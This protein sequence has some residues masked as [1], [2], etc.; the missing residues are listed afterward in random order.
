MKKT[1]IIAPK[2]PLS[3]ADGSCMR[4]MN[5]VRY[6]KRFGQVDILCSKPDAFDPA[7]DNT[8]TERYFI[9]FSNNHKI[10]TSFIR[11]VVDK[12]VYLRS[13]YVNQ[14]TPEIEEYIRDIVIKGNYDH[15]LCRY[16]FQ[17]YPLLVLDKELK[18]RIILDVDDVVTDSVYDAGTRH[19]TGFKR[20]N[21]MIDKYTLKRYYARCM[22]FGSI[23][24]CSNDD[25]TTVNEA[26]TRSKSYIVPNVCPEI[27]LPHHYRLEGYDYI[28]TLLFVG[29]LK[30]EPNLQGIIW[31]IEKIF[32]ELYG[33][34]KD[35]RLIVAG[36]TPPEELISLVKKHPNIEL[37]ENPPDIMPFY[38]QCGLVIV[39]LCAGGGTRIKIL[40]AGGA[41]RPVIST[42]IG[43]YGLGLTEGMEVLMFNDASS[44][45]AKYSQL[46]SNRE[47]YSTMV[48]NL[49]MLIKRE[50][51]LSRFFQ[52]M[53][54]VLQ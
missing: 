53:D 6:F 36:R 5:F 17:A 28:N 25:I 10:K 22:T 3:E 7:L 33:K 43:A 50:Y 13:W 27:I 40:E 11:R 54:E 45:I 15:V 2:Y 39:P 12:L 46:R 42:A 14:Y 44:F 9:N 52:C 37:Y 19:M 47:Y 34:F 35:V 49:S 20:F 26:K 8:F 23:L 51:S 29:T 30:Y 21:K 32:P 18:H 24:F 1:L 16:I 48:S 38:N 31:F 41:N 4:T